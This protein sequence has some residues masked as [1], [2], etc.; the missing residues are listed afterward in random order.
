MKEPWARTIRETRPEMEIPPTPVQRDA[1]RL[2]RAEYGG[3]CAPAL[4][5][6]A[7]AAFP[8][9]VSGVAGLRRGARHSRRTSP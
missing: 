1:H 6:P 3:E 7:G 4:D 9:L 2:S 5:R 8:A